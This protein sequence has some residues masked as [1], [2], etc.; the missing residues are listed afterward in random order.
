[1]ITPTFVERRYE[2]IYKSVIISMTVKKKKSRK[3]AFSQ[4]SCNYT[5]ITPLAFTTSRSVALLV[6]SLFRSLLETFGNFFQT[7]SRR[8]R[9]EMSVSIKHRLF[10]ELRLLNFLSF[11]CFLEFKGGREQ[12]LSSSFAKF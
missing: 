4:E 12:C 2:F 9:V 7:K 1:M 6:F 8:S 3:V 11:F 10:S 5:K